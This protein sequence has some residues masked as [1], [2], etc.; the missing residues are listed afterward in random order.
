MANSRSAKKRV[1]SSERKRII[2]Q[3]AK[4]KF[5]TAV[6]KALLSAENGSEDLP[7]KISEAFS[8]IDKAAKIGAIHKN[9]ASR[10]KSRLIKRIKAL[11]SQ[12]QIR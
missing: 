1:R 2:N 9:Q 6:K 12:E 10:R 3:I 7:L 11:T 4:S 5:R 8:K